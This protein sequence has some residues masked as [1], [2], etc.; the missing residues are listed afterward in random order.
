MIH[1]EKGAE[2]ECFT[3]WKALEFLPGNEGWKPTFDKLQNPEKLDLKRAL[4][5]EQHGICCY[6]ERRV[7]EDDCHIE[8]IEPQS[9]TGAAEAVEYGNLLCSCI[10]EHHP[11]KPLHCGHLRGNWNTPEFIK[12]FEHDCSV[13]FAYGLDGTIRA[14][15]P[16]DERARQTIK[17]LGLSIDSLVKMRKAA[18]DSVILAEPAITP[19]ELGLLAARA[20]EPGTDGAYLYGFPSMF[21]YLFMKA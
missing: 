2:P 3:D 17:H 1:I 7:S 18:L 19:E 10:K 21:V 13:H 6:C 15:D 20:T 12:P 14:R 9:T 4:L 5:R 8:H 16:A 11:G